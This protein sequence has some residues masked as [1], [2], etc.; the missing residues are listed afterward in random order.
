M[1]GLIPIFVLFAGSVAAQDSTFTPLDGPAIADTL[2]G[3]RVTYDGA[4]QEF[5]ASGR[6]LYNAGRD[7][8][9]YWA[10]RGD[11]YCSRWPPSDLWACYDMARR[12]DV[13]RFTGP[14]GDTTD[15]RLMD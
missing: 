10:V 13:V 3:Q 7:S 8:W 9:G 15:G 4:W 14:S 2:T 11:Q 12:G 6:T 5:R 1:R